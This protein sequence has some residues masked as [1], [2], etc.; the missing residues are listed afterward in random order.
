MNDERVSPKEPAGPTAG[1]IGPH[2]EKNDHVGK[3]KKY[4]KYVF[5]AKFL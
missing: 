4:A 2:F 5:Q 1:K 3:L